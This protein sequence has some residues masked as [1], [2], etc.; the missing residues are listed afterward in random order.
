M[1]CELDLRYLCKQ[2]FYVQVFLYFFSISLVFTSN[3][4]C[5]YPKYKSYY[6]VGLRDLPAFLPVFSFSPLQEPL[7]ARFSFLHIDRF[8]FF[9]KST[10]HFLQFSIFIVNADPQLGLP[11]GY[12]GPPFDP[13]GLPRLFSLFPK[14]FEYASLFWKIS[15]ISLEH[16]FGN[17]DIFFAIGK[18]LFPLYQIIFIFHSPFQ[19]FVRFVKTLQLYLI[20]L[21][22]CQFLGNYFFLLVWEPALSCSGSNQIFVSSALETGWL[23][24]KGALMLIDGIS[25]LVF[26]EVNGEHD[27][28]NANIPFYFDK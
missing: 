20:S 1:K 8:T 18:L 12:R 14:F 21:Y 24:I 27:R 4:E 11:F 2:V 15:L 28:R 9:P 17:I 25:E 6:E 22:I 13:G 5:L 3:L 7:V 26:G 23:M 19:E 10:L 16:I